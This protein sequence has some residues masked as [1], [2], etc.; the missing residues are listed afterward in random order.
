MTFPAMVSAVIEALDEEQRLGQDQS[1]LN[2]PRRARLLSSVRAVVDGWRR[3]ELSA[4]Q[5]ALAI[6]IM[7][8]T[9]APPGPRLLLASS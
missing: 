1:G 9:S 4:T 7:L 8:A 3:G 2:V 5:A 6:A